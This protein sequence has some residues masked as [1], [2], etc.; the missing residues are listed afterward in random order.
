VRTPLLLALPL[1]AAC[2][3]APKP[4]ATAAPAV[5]GAIQYEGQFRPIQQN[6]GRLGMNTTQRIFGSVQVIFR[7]S[8]G[9]S[10][11]RLSL[12]TNANASEVLSWA[13]VPGRC[14]NGAIPVLPAAQF[15]PLELS[16]NGSGEVNAAEMQV[17]LPP[18]AYHVN[19]YRGGET[20]ANVIACANLNQRDR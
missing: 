20:L 11:I 15:P 7:E 3:S 8:S 1:L 13:I 5:T 6:D 10:S 4:A 17:A 16:N 19:V 14:G 18:S 2:A 12:T 9:K